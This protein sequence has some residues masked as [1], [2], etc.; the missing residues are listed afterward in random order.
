M[1]TL[2]FVLMTVIATSASKDGE[3]PAYVPGDILSSNLIAGADTEDKC[4]KGAKILAA[5]IQ[6][7]AQDSALVAWSCVE[8][9]ASVGVIQGFTAVKRDAQEK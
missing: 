5:P 4:K 9:D 1:D 8:L 3:Q 2:W 6:Q 7:A